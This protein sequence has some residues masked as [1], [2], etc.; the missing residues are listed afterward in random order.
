MSQCNPLATR[1]QPMEAPWQSVDDP[2]TFESFVKLEYDS[3]E[4]S[5]Q[6]DKV[7]NFL[8]KNTSEILTVKV[9]ASD[10]ETFYEKFSSDVNVTYD[11]EGVGSIAVSGVLDNAIDS[12]LAFAPDHT[13]LELYLH[14]GDTLLVQYLLEEI[15]D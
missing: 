13:R 11:P 15:G 3:S 6:I 12:H 5:L 10:L 8:L 9:V 7:R 2:F 4:L 14:R 1:W